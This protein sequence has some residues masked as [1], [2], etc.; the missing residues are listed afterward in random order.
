MFSSHYVSSGRGREVKE[1]NQQQSAPTCVAFSLSRFESGSASVS[2]A[3]GR[4]SSVSNCTP[5][6]SGAISEKKNG[7]KKEKNVRFS[8]KNAIIVSLK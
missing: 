7:E 4:W 3:S 8:D 2:G 5:G 1:E 6:S